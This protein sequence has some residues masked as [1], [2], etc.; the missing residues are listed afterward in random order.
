VPTVFANLVNGQ[1][2]ITDTDAV[3]TVTLGHFANITAVGNLNFQDSAIT[4]GIFIQMG[5]GVGNFDTINITATVK[6]ITIDG[7]FDIAAVNIGGRAGF[8]AQ[9]ILA[10]INIIHLNGDRFGEVNVDDSQNQFSTNSTLNVVNDVGTLSGLAP[11]TITFDAFGMGGMTLKGGSGGNTFNVLGTFA[12]DHH[13]LSGIG[14]TLIDTGVGN[15]I[16]NLMGTGDGFVIIE[17]QNGHDFVG[18]G[19]NQRLQ[20]IQG[21]VEI[22]NAGAYTTLVVDDSAEPSAQ[23]YFL[24]KD[25]SDASLR[26]IGGDGFRIEYANNDVDFVSFSGGTGGN[27]VTI[28][29]TFKNP[30]GHS[31]VVNT[32]A[33]KDTV[34]VS[35]TTGDLTLNGQ[36]GLDSVFI[37]GVFGTAAVKGNVFLTN[38]GQRTDLTVSDFSLA[39]VFNGTGH[40]VT[41]DHAPLNGVNVGTIANLA[42]ALIQYVSNDVH[43]VTLT[44]SKFDDTFFVHSTPGIFIPVTV[45]G[46][47]G[48]DTLVV[49]STA[50][51][52]SGILGPVTFN[53]GSDTDFLIIQDQGST[54]PHTYTQTATSLTRSAPGE[55]TVTINFPGLEFL[56]V[57]KGPVGSAPLAKDLKLTKSVKA[58]QLATLTGHLEDADAADT[59]TL[60]V[61]WGDGSKGEQVQ[62]GRTPFALTHK[63]TKPGTYKVHVTWTDSTGLSNSQDLTVV[64]TKA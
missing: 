26:F 57:V 62:P 10:P 30:V 15:D 3:D 21:D 44:G 63:F 31:T 20:G 23:D 14:H 34:N 1:L 40:T 41:L 9:K 59:L 51:T 7:Q 24:G 8:G 64:V 33:G 32:G 60:T 4:K 42:P 58:G 13:D 61:N 5:S 56:Q 50:N 39:V 47:F 16:V 6:P 53:G 54:T 17:G 12:G 49:G 27:T 52:L 36:S 46:G 35:G 38:K 37:G 45:N 28:D 43:S 11:G 55:V 29:D 19:N 22:H 48:N 2:R 18:V 25:Q